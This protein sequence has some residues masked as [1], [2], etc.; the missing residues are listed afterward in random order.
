[1]TSTPNEFTD[2]PPRRINFLVIGAAKSGTT[3]LHAALSLHPQIQMPIRGGKELRHFNAPSDRD[4]LGEEGLAR[5]H[6][7][8]DW[9]EPGKLRGEASPGYLASDEAAARMRRYR[10][11]LRLVALLRAPAIRAFSAWNM[12]VH[13]GLE[14]RSFDRAVRDELAGVPGSS[15]LDG[16]RYASHLDRIRAGW[17]D[18]RLLV[19]RFDDLAAEPATAL[20][21]VCDFLGVGRRDYSRLRPRNVRIHLGGIHPKTAVLLDGAFAGDIDRLECMLGWDLGGWRSTPRSFGSWLSGESMRRTTL[22]MPGFWPMTERCRSL[23][24]RFRSP[25]KR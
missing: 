23:V 22:L 19:L 9:D 18:V 25:W 17:P 14:R 6:A 10:N 3:T 5:Y 21:C 16:G 24:A 7:A 2:G 15:Y 1:M 11:D 13:Q 20:D 8:W 4:V 12:R